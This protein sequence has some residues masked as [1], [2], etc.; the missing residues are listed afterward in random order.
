MSIDRRVTRSAARALILSTALASMSGCATA[1]PEP[2]TDAQM[3]VRAILRL[4]TEDGR[5]ICVDNV[6]N[7]KPLAIFAT[8]AVAPAPSR[9]PLAWHRVAPLRSGMKLSNTQMYHD[10]FGG[11]QP[12]L[13][14]PGDTTATLGFFAQRR[15]N[16]A[17]AKLA[18]TGESV[19]VDMGDGLGVPRAQARWW[20]LIRWSSSCGPEF[21]LSDPV[22]AKDI[23]YI[24]VRSDHWGTTYALQPRGNDWVPVAQ[25]NTWLF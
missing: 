4:L 3:T 6:T 2:L 17:A 1:P 18:R 9:R 25:W 19:A 23:A 21:K 5:S 13:A 16:D 10:T 15:L 7:G 24:T 11:D 14:D 12:L 8:M 20:P 22:V